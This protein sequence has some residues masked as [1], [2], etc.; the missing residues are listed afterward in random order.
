MSQF[1]AN[2]QIASAGWADRIYSKTPTT[3]ET[4]IQNGGNHIEVHL[5]WKAGQTANQAAKIIADELDMYLATK[6]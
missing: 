4:Q 6:G 5:D 2:P 3:S 1:D